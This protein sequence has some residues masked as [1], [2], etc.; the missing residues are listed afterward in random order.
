MTPAPTRFGFKT[1]VFVFATIL[2]TLGCA[3]VRPEPPT[4]VIS[5][6]GSHL[7]DGNSAHASAFSGFEIKVS[8]RGHVNSP[9]WVD[10]FSPLTINH[11]IELAEG[12]RVLDLD[13]TPVAHVTRSDG[14][15]FSV[16]RNSWA[17]FTLQNDD[18]VHIPKRLFP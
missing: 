13:H 3:Q 14:R 7:I 18:Y 11:A 16:H 5:H 2:L 4:K 9:G 8:V 6:T 1:Q 15:K 17:S 10:L 12:I